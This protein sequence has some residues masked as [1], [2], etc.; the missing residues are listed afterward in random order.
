MGGSILQLVTNSGEAN[1]W[2]T[3]QPQITFF[4]KVYRRYTRFASELIK[5]PMTNPVH[6]GSGSSAKLLPVG[7][8][9]YRLFVVIDL[10][11]LTAEF[12]NDK[13]LDLALLLT[14]ANLSDCNL[15]KIIQSSATQEDRIEFAKII[16]IVDSTLAIYDT[17]EKIRLGVLSNFDTLVFPE[18]AINSIICPKSSF[19]EDKITNFEYDFINFKMDLSTM[20]VEKNQSYYLIHAYLKFL[21]TNGKYINTKP[22]FQPKNMFEDILSAFIF[23]DLIPNKEIL[24]MYYYKNIDLT[25]CENNTTIDVFNSYT[26]TQFTYLQDNL[27]RHQK[28][29]RAYGMNSI[30]MKNIPNFNCLDTYSLLQSLCDRE[31]TTYDIKNLFYDFGPSFYYVLNSYEI[32]INLLQSIYQPN[33]IVIGKA[34]GKNNISYSTFIDPNC[35]FQITSQINNIS[36]NM[37]SIPYVQIVNSKLNYMFSAIESQIDLLFNTYQKYL[38][39]SI[40]ANPS[41]NLNLFLLDFLKEICIINPHNFI[42]YINHN[43]DPDI[44]QD[45]IVQIT[46]TFNTIKLHITHLVNNINLSTYNPYQ[47][48]TI[49]N[50]INLRTDLNKYVL[51][52]DFN[53]MPHISDIFESCYTIIDNDCHKNSHLIKLLYQNIYDCFTTIYHNLIYQTHTSESDFNS[54]R[55][56]VK[57]F[58]CQFDNKSLRQIEFYFVAEMIV[59]HQLN[60]MYTNIFNITDTP[61]IVSRLLKKINK[62]VNL[63]NKTTGCSGPSGKTTG[64]SGPSGKTTGCSGPSGK[65]TG[66]SGPSGKIPIH[67][68][69]LKYHNDTNIRC[70]SNAIL[71]LHPVYWVNSNCSPMQILSEYNSKSQSYHKLKY[72]TNSGS[73]IT[74]CAINPIEFELL[75]LIKLIEELIK[76]TTNSYLLQQIELTMSY[77]MSYLMT[78]PIDHSLKSALK[79]YI[80]LDTYVLN[81]IMHVCKLYISDK[82]I[83][84]GYSAD[85]VLDKIIH[86]KNKY[87]M[88]YEYYVKYMGTIKSTCD[89]NFIKNIS[90]TVLL[91]PESFPCKI[92]SIN[93]YVDELD[94]GGKYVASVLIQYKQEIYASDICYNISTTF[95]AITDLYLYCVD[96]NLVEYI[97]TKIKK[98]KEAMVDKMILVKIIT[99]TKCIDK[100]N[101]MAM[102]YGIGG[103][104][105][106]N[107]LGK[108]NLSKFDFDDLDYFLLKNQLGLKINFNTTFKQHILNDII[109][110]NLIYYLNLIP[111]SD[112]EFIL[113]FFSYANQYDLSSKSIINPIINNIVGRN[114]SD[115]LVQ[116]L[117]HI[118]DCVMDIN[119]TNFDGFGFDL[120]PIQIINN[121]NLKHNINHNIPSISAYIFERSE[122]INFV[123]DICH[124]SIVLIDIRRREL[125]KLQKQI[126]NILYRNKSAKSAWIR[127]LGHFIISDVTLYSNDQVIDTNPSDWFEIFH[128]VSKS[129]GQEYGYNKMIG[130]I[131]KLT[132]FDNL[133][134]PA[135]TLVIPL[136]FYCNRNST[137]SLPLSAGLNTIYKLNIKF[138]DLCELTYKEEFSEFVHKTKSNCA[139]IPTISNAYIMAEY[140][141]LSAEERRIF[142]SGV[143]EYIM[144]ELQTDISN[145]I[146][147]TDLNPV[148]KLG[149]SKK[150]VNIMSNRIKTAVEYFDP[151]AII[152][153]TDNEFNHIATN[154]NLIDRSDLE[155]MPCVDRTGAK[156]LRYIKNSIDTDPKIHYKRFTHRYYFGNPSEFMAV[157]AKPMIHTNP[158]M[159]CD[160]LNYF[161]GEHQWSNYGLYSFYDLS[162][163]I[164]AKEEYC[165]NLKHKLHLHTDPK[166]GFM[167]LINHVLKNNEL[168]SESESESIQ[169]IKDAYMNNSNPICDYTSILHLKKD[170]MKLN[171]DIWVWEDLLELIRNIYLDIQINIGI[172]INLPSELDI[173]N[174]YK[175]KPTE[176]FILDKLK[177]KAGLIYILNKYEISNI[178]SIVHKIYNLYNEIKVNNLINLILKFVNV[179][180]LTTEK[181]IESFLNRYCL[182]DNADLYIIKLLSNFHTDDNRFKCFT[183]EP[184]SSPDGHTP[185]SISDIYFKNIIW[186]IMPN[187]NYKI[188]PYDV[189]NRICSQLNSQLNSFINHNPIKL[190]DYKKNMI[191]NPC[192]NPIAGGV[193]RFDNY[194][195]NPVNSDQIYWSA[196]QPYLYMR[197][198]PGPGINIFSW[199]IDPFQSQSTGSANLT[200][201]DN[202]TADYDLHPLIG[203]NYP[204]QLCTFVQ[205][206]NLFRCMS[207]L[208]GKAWQYTTDKRC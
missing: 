186:Q 137:S 145:N 157:I 115:I 119:L 142:V 132:N 120:K 128:E 192:V 148:Y 72:S 194:V 165:I 41:I 178:G 196:I 144:E 207:G 27:S 147:D 49:V 90:R 143:Q 108:I 51:N 152:Y 182:F 81:K 28:L 42:L 98:Y 138:R 168:E 155:L 24:L 151:K 149:Q 169:F 13:T 56:F 170:L 122:I 69:N 78:C 32:I 74:Y 181:I 114:K 44:T 205:S 95:T 54:I 134:K 46:N 23:T 121:F 158:S 75:K 146:T 126:Y 6:F 174:A 176:K 131:D 130:N 33:P 162:R 100:I 171:F 191:L 48:C 154:C 65:T 19:S 195:R 17:E 101:E 125:I 116:L 104:E 25:Y 12:I 97:S 140:I 133:P 200:K 107:Y 118:W 76:P 190:I 83:D 21:Y 43:I 106:L 77:T 68:D 53:S 79:E 166:F 150:I 85:N 187:D 84:I 208:S 156:K 9:L 112:Y 15:K 55:P 103:E 26:K 198:T 93:D 38:P 167:N 129:D 11:S 117:D 60:D 5:I 203:T 50:N 87:L 36:P 58:F 59:T 206:I 88:E 105:F 29:H 94:F 163:I 96:N 197:H 91:C 135:Y 73:I 92:K 161:Y 14:S 64:C 45:E 123:K 113:D 164:K 34:I 3:Q 62:S 189:V 1:R 160:E 71:K 35:K 159:R 47:P 4:K 80:K 193:L 86:L 201:I 63:V 22:L 8:L 110:T 173:M 18:G 180:V 179:G 102:S 175:I 183:F 31:Y 99:E 39:I 70:E 109:D 136:I 202:F 188:I 124:K 111:N 30:K 66:C 139:I 61:H 172:V 57:N 40:E 82:K 89:G 153:V 20:W 52:F 204:V 10:P 199:A 16:D 141:Y 67:F 184:G 185:S 37:V 7:D 177:F 2:I 127:K